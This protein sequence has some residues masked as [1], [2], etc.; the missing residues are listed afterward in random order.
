M[1]QKK[2]CRGSALYLLLR[3]R[4]NLLFCFGHIALDV[5]AGHLDGTIGAHGD[6]LLEV[7]RELALAVVGHLGRAKHGRI[8]RPDDEEHSQAR[9]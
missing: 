8:L 1:E 7:A 4:G 9:N 3:Y 2:H 5:E 6:G